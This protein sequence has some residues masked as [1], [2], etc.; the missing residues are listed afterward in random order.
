MQLNCSLPPKL[1]LSGYLPSAMVVERFASGTP[2][3]EHGRA[4]LPTG[5]GLG[6]DVDE[7]ALGEPVL[8][9]E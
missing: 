2:A 5:P 4:R 7:A 8:H 1:L 6:I 9:V 3:A